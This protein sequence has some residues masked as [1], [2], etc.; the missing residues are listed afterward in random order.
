MV[1]R[2]YGK[3]GRLRRLTS[4]LELYR[5]LL[6]IACPI[7]GWC[8]RLHPLQFDICPDKVKI[9]G[10]KVSTAGDKPIWG[11]A[12]RKNGLNVSIQDHSR[13]ASTQIPNSTNGIE[14][15]EKQQVNAVLLCSEQG[16]P[17]SNQSTIILK[18]NGIHF[19]RMAFLKQ[20]F[21]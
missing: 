10:K 6:E 11:K 12:Y 8:R 7:F 3:S 14:P 9:V 15:S 4:G 21:L 5:A 13:A 16:I 20:E 18:L 2:G 17:G 19:L 1:H